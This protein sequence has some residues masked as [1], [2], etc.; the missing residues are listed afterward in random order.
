MDIFQSV[1]DIFTQK[2]GVVPELVR[3][4]ARLVEDIGMDSVDRVQLATAVEQQFRVRVPDEKLDA[5][6]MVADVVAVIEAL[7]AA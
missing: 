7:R 4:E 5:M 2:L 3:P 1:L 6:V